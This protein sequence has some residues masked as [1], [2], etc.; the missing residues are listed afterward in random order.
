MAKRMNGDGYIR[1]RKD[2][3]WE[4]REMCGYRDDGSRN[5]VTFYGRTQKEVKEKVDAHRA[6]KRDGILIQ[7]EYPFEQWAEVWFAHHKRTI[8]ETTQENYKYTQR[9]LVDYFQ[10]YR[11]DEI[12][13]INVENFIYELRDCGRSD[14][15]VAKCRAQLFQI[16]NLAVAN[17]LIRKNPVA[18]AQKSHSV[19]KPEEKPCF[20]AEEVKRLMQELP[21][22]KIGLSIRLMLGTGMRCQELLA[23]RV[24]DIEPDG[25]EVRILKAVKRVKG[26]TVVGTPKSTKSYRNVVIPHNLRPY[27][28]MLRNNAQGYIWESPKTK[29][30]PCSHSH[31]ADKFEEALECIEGM[32]ILTP[33]C[34]RHTYVSQMQSLGICMETI[35]SLCGH[36]EKSMTQHYLHVQ[37]PVQDVAVASFSDM[38][39]PQL[40]LTI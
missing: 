22:S 10:G 29:G 7:K 27:I 15:Y 9:I 14:S 34:C 4:Y 37:R 30:R 19:E 26:T 2:G 38:F 6:N 20:T 28:A 25:S 1:R 32:R 17:D 40:E 16:L 21:L 11:L 18:Y 5:M 33:H 13:P 12:K 35:Q 3:R 36:A 8:S 23:L 39:V 24:E 31:Y